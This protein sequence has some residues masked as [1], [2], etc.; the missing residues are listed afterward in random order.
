ME[1]EKY[2]EGVRERQ[3]ERGRKRERERERKR[4]REKEREGEREKEREREKEGERE[5]EMTNSETC[6]QSNPRLLRCV[7]HAFCELSAGCRKLV[8]AK[9]DLVRR[10]V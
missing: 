7:V 4:E 5:R 10:Q 1:R 9:L 6:S 8:R 2:S 3:G